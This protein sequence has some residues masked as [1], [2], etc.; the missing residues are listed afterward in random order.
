[1]ASLPSRETRLRTLLT[2]TIILGTFG[3]AAPC[4]VI[5]VAVVVVVVVVVD[6]GGGDDDVVRCLVSSSISFAS[7]VAEQH[8][9]P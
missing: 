4:R 2:R 8:P 6:G 5:V 3:E 1:M 9:I 7:P